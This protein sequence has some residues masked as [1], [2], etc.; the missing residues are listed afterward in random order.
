MS[1]T[2]DVTGA[3][4]TRRRMMAWS[5][6]DWGSAA[7]NAV[8]VTFVFSVY[9]VDGVGDDLDGPISA[10]SWLAW[11]TA[12][13]AFVIAALAPVTGRQADA[14][15]R[16]KRSLASLTGAVVLV[17]ALMFF[18]KDDA[19]YLWLGLLLLVLGDI[20]FELAQVPYFAMLRQV[21]T[22]ANVGRV[23]AF[24]WALG[25]LGGIVLLLVCFFGLITGDGGLLGLS[26]DEGLN[27][28]LVAVLAALWFAV[29]AAPVFLL[30]PELP[31]DA[32]PAPKTGL[33]DA[34]RGV[35]ADLKRMWSEDRVVV[36]FL[37][38]SAIF[39]D[40]LAGVFAFG[41][42]LAVTTYD[43]ADDSVIVF[44]IV[45]NVFAAAGALIAGRFDDRYGPRIVI[46]V[47]LGCMLGAG[48][49]LLFVSGSGMFWIFG[50]ILCL[51]V[52]PAQSAARTYLVRLTRPGM[53]GQNFGFYAMTGRAAS[54]LS[55]LLFGLFVFLGGSDRWGILG[56]MIVL[57]AGLFLLLRVPAQIADR[58]AE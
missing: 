17:T 13:G 40:G 10:S 18:V 42:I 46:V 2:A 35:F 6:W 47:S 38:A 34:Y 1:H 28:R 25:Y 48:A 21:S 32:S 20:L 9:L 26:T 31:A 39:R 16:R 12:A 51:F 52:G 4:A 44:G 3:A 55:P 43:F 15:G 22:P 8:I 24:G 53:E 41:A 50:L 36:K 14:G 27:I 56:I 7:F 29:F 33:L 5:L 30:V 23:S 49:V 45:A 37:L 58:A 57:A 54:F 19:S 11:A